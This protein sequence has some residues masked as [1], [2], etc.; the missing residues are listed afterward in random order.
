MNLD[1]DIIFKLIFVRGTLEAAIAPGKTGL[2]MEIMRDIP[3]T[4]DS[5]VEPAVWRC[6]ALHYAAICQRVRESRVSFRR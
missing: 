3:F 4:Y 2:F 1:M 6:D 5:R